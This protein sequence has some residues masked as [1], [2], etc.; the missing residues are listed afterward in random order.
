MSDVVAN[1]LPLF[2]E[3]AVEQVPE[4]EQVD[5]DVKVGSVRL[6]DGSAGADIW[7]YFEGDDA[8][9]EF[10]GWRS[11]GSWWSVDCA[12]DENVEKT[13]KAVCTVASVLDQPVEYIRVTSVVYSVDMP[14]CT[15]TRAAT[16]NRCM[17]FP[18]QR[19]VDVRDQDQ[20][21]DVHMVVRR[22]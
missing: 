10:Q 22:C 9:L 18:S 19:W 20:W 3:N 14:D 2:V 4:P 1:L 17:D 21:Y 13:L 12:M 6:E 5:E 8:Y 7:A 11:D 15:M 16:L